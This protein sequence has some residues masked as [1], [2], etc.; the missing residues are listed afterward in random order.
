MRPYVNISILR[1]FGRSIVQT[2]YGIEDGE[3]LEHFTTL[4]QTVFEAVIEVALP[5]RYWVDFLPWLKNI[6]SWMPGATFQKQAA[7]Y[8]KFVSAAIE[9]PFQ[10]ARTMRAVSEIPFIVRPTCLC[11]HV[12]QE[13]KSQSFASV[14][15]RALD[16]SNHDVT[17]LRDAAAIAYIGLYSVYFILNIY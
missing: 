16:I 7:Y 3:A 10:F 11:L 9:E 14:V 12:Y 15:P 13:G 17:A 2:V 6:P 4:N 5:G 8:R 1:H